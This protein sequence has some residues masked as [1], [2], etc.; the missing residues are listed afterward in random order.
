MYYPHPVSYT[1]LLFLSHGLRPGC[2]RAIVH[3]YSGV[4][5]S[6]KKYRPEGRF[7]YG[8]GKIAVHFIAPHIP[9]GD[10]LSGK[11]F[12]AGQV[13]RKLYDFLTGNVWFLAVFLHLGNDKEAIQQIENKTYRRS[14]P[15]VEEYCEKW[16]LMQ[17][18]QILSL[19]HI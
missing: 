2:F 17:S 14:T 16:L 15:T 4:R 3:A 19:I 12:C 7:W 9:A 11:Q 8:Q 13:A 1:H 6:P 5:K 10:F 18:A